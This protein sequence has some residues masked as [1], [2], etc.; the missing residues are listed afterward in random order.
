MLYEVITLYPVAV[1]QVKVADNVRP[2]G[3]H[4]LEFNMALDTYGGNPGP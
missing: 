2:I 1:D 4:V 3:F